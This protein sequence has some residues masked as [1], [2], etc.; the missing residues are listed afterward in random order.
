ML[1]PKVWILVANQ[2]KARVYQYA[3]E[4][5][6]PRLI[7]QMAHPVAP[8]G[9]ESTEVAR[10]HDADVFAK[11]IAER[12]KDARRRERFERLALVCDPKF[13]GH[14]RGALDLPTMRLVVAERASGSINLEDAEL[15]ESLR[16]LIEPAALIEAG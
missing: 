16:G 2:T 14:V 7:L 6:S 11:A 12:L 1:I 8:H 10:Q 4:I 13:L 9:R 3:G 15:I 5:D